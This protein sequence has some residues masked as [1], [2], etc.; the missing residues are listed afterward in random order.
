MSKKQ[1]LTLVGIG[2]LLVLLIL[3]IVLLVILGREDPPQEPSAAADGVAYLQSLEQQDPARVDQ[4]LKEQRY[5]EFL[6]RRE[7]RLRQLESGETSVWSL[8]EDYVLLGD[9]RAEGFGFYGYMSKDRC[10]AEMGTNID[11]TERHLEQ[12]KTLNPSMVFLSFGI[13]DL[14]L[15]VWPTAED[16][17]AEYEQVIGGIR[18][19]CP[20]AKIYINSIIPSLE[21]SSAYAGTCDLI[22][23]YNGALKSLCDRT[24]GCYYIDNDAI[25]QEHTDLYESDGIHFVSEF[26]PIWATNMIMEVYDSENEISEDPAA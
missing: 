16:Y 12:I 15:G 25:A 21:W 1:T 17:A 26:Y 19:E 13:N 4:I 24:D 10:L 8:F 22:P 3:G 20:Q 11:D 6:Q 14:L 18:R 2:V 7:E 5:Q 9:S 23:D